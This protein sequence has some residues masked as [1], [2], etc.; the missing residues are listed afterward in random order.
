MNLKRGNGKRRKSPGRFV[1]F[2]TILE[3]LSSGTRCRTMHLRIIDRNDFG[4]L[5]TS[6]QRVKAV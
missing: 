3:S 6:D 1:C 5:F 2:G 4:R